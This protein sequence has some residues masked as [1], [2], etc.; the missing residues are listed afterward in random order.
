MQWWTGIWVVFAAGVP[1]CA[2]V[3]QA[4]PVPTPE[5]AAAGGVPLKTLQR[6]HGV[7]LTQCGGCHELIPPDRVKTADWQLVVPGMCWNAGL[8]RAD[9]ALVLK[10]VLAAKKR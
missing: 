4:P 3:P 8:T 9:E 10:Y 1:G 2:I 5:M 6:G 7:Y